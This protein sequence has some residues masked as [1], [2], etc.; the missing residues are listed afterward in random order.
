MTVLDLY[1]PIRKN[2]YPM[3]A[4]GLIGVL[5]YFVLIKS[6]SISG[7]VMVSAVAGLLILIWA[8]LRPGQFDIEAKQVFESV[9]NGRPTFLNV[10]SNT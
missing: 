9:G 2:S 6:F 3:M 5:T 10:F 8:W 1:N 7:L 4:I